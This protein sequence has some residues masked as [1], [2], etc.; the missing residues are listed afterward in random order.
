MNILN[1]P[2]RIGG[3]T[4]SSRLVMPPMATGKS[5]DEG[6]ASEAICSYY[7]EKTAG[8]ALGL[9]ITEHA[10]ISPEGR[11]GKGQSS[12]AS[13]IT[14]ESLKRLTDTIHK[15]GVPVFAQLNHAGAAADPSLT[16]LPSIGPSMTEL[17]RRGTKP[18]SIMNVDEIRRVTEAFALAAVRAKR[19]GYDGVEI[20]SAHGY[21]LNQFYSPLT[22]RRTDAYTGSTLEGRIRFH[23]EII[24]AVRSAVGAD[25]PVALRLGACDYMEGGSTAED[26]TAACIAFE[27]AG[28]DLLDISGGLCGYTIPGLANPPEGYFSPL[29][30]AI[31]N[32]VRIPVILTGGVV[33]AQGA[34]KLLENGCADLIGV[35]R[36]LL[37]DSKW[38]VNAL[39]SCRKEK[40]SSC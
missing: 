14:A 9:V 39:S 16:G 38:A 19:A 26:S 30:A 3:L 10:F 13:D 31:R 33:T 4:L 2:F 32:A 35:G 5:T 27:K 34:E 24:A 21:L 1:S 22:N 20:H 17:P 37:M 11:A 6:S 29:T 12:L 28:I 7:D 25:Y 40:D 18:D 15:N 8:G 36:A 23:L